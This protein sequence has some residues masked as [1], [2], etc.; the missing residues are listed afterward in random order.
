MIFLEICQ[1]F[2][3][4]VDY[5]QSINELALMVISP[6]LEVALVSEHLALDLT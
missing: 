5:D 3:C 6:G 1:C 2:F 4:H